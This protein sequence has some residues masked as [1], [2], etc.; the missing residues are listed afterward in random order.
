MNELQ[1][2][3]FELADN[4]ARVTFNRPDAANAI[5]M[6]AAITRLARGSAPVIAAVQ[7]PAAGAAFFEKRR[8]TFRG[9]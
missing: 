6:H 5:D 2:L 8:A 9:R 1:T 4:V 3:R 7:G